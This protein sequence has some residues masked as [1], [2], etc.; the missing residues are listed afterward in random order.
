MREKITIR[1]SKNKT[2]CG[3]LYAC[4]CLFIASGASAAVNVFFSAEK[5]SLQ[6]EF[7][8]ATTN[9]YEATVKTGLF[10]NSVTVTITGKRNYTPPVVSSPI[11]TV[12]AFDEC[13]VY[14]YAFGMEGERKD[15]L[16]LISGLKD[17]LL[18]TK[19]CGGMVSI[20]TVPANA[21][22]DGCWIAYGI[23]TSTITQR[24]GMIPKMI[25]R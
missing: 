11:A 5:A 12:T 20:S 14:G 3:L 13:F 7:I 8:A 22:L 23:A 24:D 1:A 6:N 2:V 25:V 9:Q 21:F 17:D 19:T 10:S 16:K 18:S 4:A 15:N